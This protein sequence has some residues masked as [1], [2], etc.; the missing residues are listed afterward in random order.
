M[1][2]WP[3][4]RA[5]AGKLVVSSHIATYGPSHK[6]WPKPA[7]ASLQRRH[8]WLVAMIAQRVGLVP[9]DV[10]F[11]LGKES[12]QL[13]RP[14]ARLCACASGSRQDLPASFVPVGVSVSS[15]CC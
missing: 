10:F 1:P 14:G 15:S 3:S 12:R 13:L 9:K 2:G 4:W 8:D 6:E 11:P 5:R 7:L